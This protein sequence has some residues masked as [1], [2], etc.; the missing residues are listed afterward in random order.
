[1]IAEKN[2]SKKAPVMDLDY[3]LFNYGRF[4]D[5]FYNKA[6]HLIFVPLIQFTVLILLSKHFP[7]IPSFFDQKILGVLAHPQQRLNIP[8]GLILA[9]MQVVY[10]KVDLLTAIVWGAPSW[11][12][13][14]LAQVVALDQGTYLGGSID[15]IVWTVFLFSWI[16]QFVGHGVF[17]SKS[18]ML[19]HF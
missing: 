19:T 5:D 12:M 2:F 14:F 13:F 9:T 4:H 6:I 15:V 16:M 1:M 3:F 8:G 18:C 7:D 17:E 10:L 11:L